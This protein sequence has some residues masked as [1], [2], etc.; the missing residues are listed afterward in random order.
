MKVTEVNKE[1]AL[2][3]RQINKRIKTGDQICKT[4]RKRIHN[5]ADSMTAGTS[6]DEPLTKRQTKEP[7]SVQ[8]MMDI[9]SIGMN[10]SL[11]TFF[12]IQFEYSYTR[13]LQK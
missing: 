11:N 8:E 13:I 3:A 6:K 7:E 9:S 10:A 4:C 5:E 2:K 12:S 1:L